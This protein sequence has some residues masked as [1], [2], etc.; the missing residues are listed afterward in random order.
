GGNAGLARGCGARSQPR[1]MPSTPA[2]P[3]HQ[4]PPEIEGMSLEERAER[5][6]A[7]FRDRKADWDAFADAKIDGFHRAQHRFI[8]AGGSGKHGDPSVIPAGAFTLSVMF[9]PP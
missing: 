3:V 6:V 7:R 2:P 1:P 4:K 5:Y 8:G 9:V